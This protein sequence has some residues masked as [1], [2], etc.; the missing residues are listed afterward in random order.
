MQ[1][2]EAIELN[3]LVIHGIS[4]LSYEPEI[5]DREEV[6]SEGLRRFFEEHIRNCVKSPGARAAKFA[7][8]DRTV[9]ACA[10]RILASPDEFVEQCAVIGRWFAHCMR[11]SSEVRTYLAIALFTDSG[12]NNRYLAILKMDPVNAYVRRS[13][14]PDF[15]QVQ[16]LPDPT[17]HLGRFAILQPYTEDARYDLIFRN[18]P[19]WKDE[20]P[21]SA[22]VWLNRFLE[23]DEVAT[24]RQM[25][26][27][28]VKETER[29][30]E[31]HAD[32]I[33][34][35]SAMQLRR[36][37]RTLAQSDE[38]DVEE[39]AS[40]AISDEEKRSDYIARLLDRG[41]TETSF[42]PDRAWAERA[43]RRT[44]YLC[45]DGVTISGPSD[46]IDDIVQILPKTPDRKTRIVI[47]TRKFVMK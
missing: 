34:E 17:R 25:T 18:Q 32:E 3:R 24:S 16:I 10:E 35:E 43:S 40:A 36:A 30:I 15:E 13:D 22:A 7:G 29:W 14:G 26:Q 37:V 1:Q 12:D 33:G 19:F 28:V 41:L 11:S 44:T 4:N 8:S 27:L 6:L 47:E 45:D 2:I 42:V 31:A 23:A 46:V 5:A 9:S 38:L 21:E 20:D 39:V